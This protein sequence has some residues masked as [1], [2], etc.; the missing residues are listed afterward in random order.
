[1][2]RLR[3]VDC[4]QIVRAEHL[5]SLTQFGL[6]RLEPREYIRALYH[7]PP[8]V[9]SL[10]IFSFKIDDYPD[11]WP[12]F[13]QALLRLRDQI[14]ILDTHTPSQFYMNMYWMLPKLK[15]IVNRNGDI[16]LTRSRRKRVACALVHSLPSHIGYF[17]ASFLL[18]LT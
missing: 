10:S 9:T 4:R 15:S 6:F 3:I 1:M 18:L 11:L 13:E 17:A 2:K 5:T 16:D 14:E 8:T 12:E 7:V